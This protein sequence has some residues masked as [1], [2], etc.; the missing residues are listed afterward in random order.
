LGQFLGRGYLL[1]IQIR[2]DSLTRKSFPNHEVIRISPIDVIPARDFMQPVAV[3]QD[4]ALL[5]ESDPV[6]PH[7]PVVRHE[8]VERFAARAVHPNTLPLQHRVKNISLGIGMHPI[9][10][11]S[12]TPY[13]LYSPLDLFGR[14]LKIHQD[15]GI[16]GIKIASGQ[17]A[18]VQ[19]GTVSGQGEAIHA[20]AVQHR[21]IVNG[22]LKTG[23]ILRAEL[24]VQ[25][26]SE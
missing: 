16:D 17:R 4:G 10:C 20:D 2:L 1:G 9:R 24:P 8:I 15:G 5:I 21:L 13:R 22:K 3:E 18:I 19:G 26:P 25:H 14:S 12:F 23:K 11:G 6:H 7:H